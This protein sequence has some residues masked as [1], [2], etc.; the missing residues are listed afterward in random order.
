LREAV[1]LL[2][3]MQKRLEPSLALALFLQDREGRLAGE[4]TVWRLLRE[5]KRDLESNRLADISD[6]QLGVLFRKHFTRSIGAIA[7]T[8]LPRLTER[9]TLAELLLASIG[10]DLPVLP[11]CNEDGRVLGLIDQND[12]LTGLAKALAQR[13]EEVQASE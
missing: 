5:L 10:K 4:L 2:A 3:E 12:L 8:D 1:W 9:T 6:R 7:R 13:G 11:V